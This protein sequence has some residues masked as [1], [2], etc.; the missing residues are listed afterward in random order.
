MTAT[1]A[2]GAFD[3]HNL[4]DLLLAHVARASLGH[5]ELQFAGLAARDLRA[6]GGVATRA[7]HA[8][9][10]LPAAGARLLHVGGEILTCTARQ[11][12]VMLLARKD[13]EPTLSWLER[14]PQAEAGWR[15]TMLGTEA[16]MPYVA[17]AR[18][19]PGLAAT[20]FAGVGGVG[21]DRLPA[22]A[23]DA[24]IARLAAAR[25][26]GVR[27]RVTL[28]HLHAAGLAPRLVPDPVEQIAALFG[29][30]IRARGAVPPVAAVRARFEDGY[31]ALQLASEFG[32]DATLD[33]LAQALSR[34][35]A[36]NR[37]GLVLFQAGA[38]PWHD[39]AGVLYRLAARLPGGRAAV[40][41]SIDAWDLCALLAHA[42]VCAST[43]LHAFI[44]AGA[45]AVP[46]VAMQ[47]SEDGEHAAK[48]QAY[49]QTWHSMEAGSTC[50][51]DQLGAAIEH[52]LQVPAALRESEARCRAVAC[53]DGF[54]AL[55]R[56]RRAAPSLLIPLG[57]R[58]RQ[59]RRLG[60][61]I[62]LC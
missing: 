6:V 33:R 49:L 59:R 27:D 3:R 26:V 17:D 4:G 21:L 48:L 15:R 62:T 50:G 30:V 40:F 8:L 47:L 25:A 54:E 44:V 46:A 41:D 57:G 58:R 36:R 10:G 43:S 23:R 51:P 45:F 52:A 19:L 1:I 34:L 16:E 13:V 39:D 32:D 35:C 24:V 55:M 5:G 18:Q 53:R 38:A 29:D 28:S 2:F 12:A 31:L 61:L 37:L 20:C 22:E 56:R 9:P 11:A 60:V 42:R 14:H 7:L